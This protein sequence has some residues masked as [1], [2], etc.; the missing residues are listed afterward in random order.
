MTRGARG[1]LLKVLAMMGTV[2]SPPSAPRPGPFLSRMRQLGTEVVRVIHAE[3]TEDETTTEVVAHVQPEKGFFE[4]DAPVFEGDV[5]EVHDPRLGPEGR[6]RRV[7]RKVSVL[8]SAPGGMAHTEVAWGKGAPPR[9]APVRRLTFE[10][11]HQAVRAAAGDL[12][13]DG[14]YE[15]AVAEAF[16][17]VDLR[18]RQLSGL[19]AW[20]A[21]LMGAAFGTPTPRLDVSTRSGRSAEDERAGFLAIFRGATI[22]VRNP[23]AHD[24]FQPTDPQQALEYLAFAS[25]LHRRLDVAEARLPPEESPLGG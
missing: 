2:T 12:Y 1:A 17:S 22:G 18:V 15:S 21:Q 16:K 10:N 19:D 13:A 11:L 20:G 4:V 14:H 5:V 23:G 9:V 7:A 8:A 3:G 6:E 24:L 25:L